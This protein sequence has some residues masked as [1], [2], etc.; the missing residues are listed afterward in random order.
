MSVPMDVSKHAGLHIIPSPTNVYHE[1][2]LSYIH[3]QHLLQ[4]TCT[5][6][7]TN[8]KS[9]ST[10]ISLLLIL[11]T[12]VQVHAVVMRRSSY[13]AVFKLKVV[14]YAEKHGN[15]CEGRAESG[16]LVSKIAVLSQCG[17]CAH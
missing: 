1:K 13:T 2:H 12:A 15:R 7:L 16:Y 9:V 11:E 10:C 8:I 3:S 5:H 6:T 17:G 4:Q 14:E